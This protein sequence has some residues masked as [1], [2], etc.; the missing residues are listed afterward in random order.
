MGP[1]RTHTVNGAPLLSF[2]LA[3]SPL[4]STLCPFMNHAA[5][6]ISPNAISNFIAHFPQYTLLHMLADKHTCI[7]C[8]HSEHLLWPRGL[9][10]LECYCL[11][12]TSVKQSK[13]RLSLDVFSCLRRVPCL[14][15]FQH[16]LSICALMCTAYF[17]R[18]AHTVTFPLCSWQIN[19]KGSGSKGQGK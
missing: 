16:P 13:T 18:P 8:A 1:A 19:N 15:E 9:V 12:V 6:G 5:D 4:S 10:Y 2:P 3:P 7:S 14:G 17:W 11:W